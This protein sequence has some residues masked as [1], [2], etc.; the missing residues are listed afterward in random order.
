ML[1][2]DGLLQEPKIASVSCAQASRKLSLLVGTTS[3]A[4]KSEI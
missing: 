4:A 3:A 2:A 1:T